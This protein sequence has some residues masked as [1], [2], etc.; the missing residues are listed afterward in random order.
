M[1][2][3]KTLEMTEP[4]LAAIRRKQ[5]LSCG[6]VTEHGRGRIRTAYRNE[7]KMGAVS[8]DVLEK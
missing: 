4:Q 7:R 6:P 5:E 1:A 3:I 2:H 8:R